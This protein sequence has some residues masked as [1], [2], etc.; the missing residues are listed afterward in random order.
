MDAGEKYLVLTDGFKVYWDLFQ[1]SHTKR[2]K[3]MLISPGLLERI[4]ANKKTKP[5]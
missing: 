2:G 5:K 4:E 1:E 3:L